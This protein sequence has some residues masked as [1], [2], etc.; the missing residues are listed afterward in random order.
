LLLDL[1]DNGTAT[2]Q[3]L[4]QDVSVTLAANTEMED[5]LG[6]RFSVA[7]S[8]LNFEPDVSF[9]RLVNDETK[10]DQ[11]SLMYGSTT[12]KEPQETL[13]DSEIDGEVVFDVGLANE[14]NKYTFNLNGT[15][16]DSFTRSNVA[17]VEDVLEEEVDRFVKDVEVVVESDQYDLT[18]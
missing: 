8:Y 18:A 17:S 12:A 2:F 1:D 15:F 9:T 3:A 6:T 14:L 11:K 16:P 7:R 4:I 10:D 5:E 13:V